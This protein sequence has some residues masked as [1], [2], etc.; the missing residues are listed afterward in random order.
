MKLPSLGEQPLRMNL[1][2]QHHLYRAC[3]HTF[4]A[5][6]QLAPAQ[7][8][9]TRQAVHEIVTLVEKFEK[10]YPILCRNVLCSLEKI[11]KT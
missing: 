10:L 5:Q 2:K 11:G 6:T 3:H 9:I 7:H 8:A 4:S 1:R